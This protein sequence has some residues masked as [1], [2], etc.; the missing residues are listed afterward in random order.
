MKNILYY[1][2]WDIN[3]QIISLYNRNFMKRNNL[4]NIIYLIMKILV[5][6]KILNIILALQKEKNIGKE[7]FDNLDSSKEYSIYR[8]YTMTI[9]DTIDTILEKFNVTKE[10]LADYNDLDNL[11]VGSKII[12]PSLDE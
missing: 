8:V 10:V 11:V 12:I 6:M 1:Y 3:C 9:D 4:L 5:K 7:L 2:L